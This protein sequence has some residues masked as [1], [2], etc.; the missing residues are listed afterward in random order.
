MKNQ[1]VV[2]A[3]RPKGEPKP[4]DFRIEEEH[5]PQPTDGEVLLRTLYLSLDPYM[6]GRMSDAKSYAKPVEIGAPMEGETVAEVV[7][8]RNTE[9]RPGDLIQAR[10]GWRTYAAI[11]VAG[12]C[13]VGPAL[14]PVSPAVGGRRLPGV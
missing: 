4:S 6:R 8:S 1:R 13:R 3:S 5:I 14:A 7:E 10:I 2:L 12:F 9:Y 11:S